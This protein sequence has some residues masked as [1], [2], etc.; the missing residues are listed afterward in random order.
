MAEKKATAPK[1]SAPA[2][3]AAKVEAKP[4]KP[5]AP[6][7]RTDSVSAAAA[8]PALA[9]TK[10]S[11][12]I[13][14]ASVVKP[15]SAGE[16]ARMVAEAAYYIAEKRGFVPGRAEQDWAEAERQIASMLNRA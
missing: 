10:P 6:A 8:K 13:K 3:A 12:P 11:A 2:P 14:P 5:A 15:L 4:A 9:P 16:R 1:K 7:A